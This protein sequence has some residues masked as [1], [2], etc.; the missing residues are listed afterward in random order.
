MGNGLVTS[1]QSLFKKAPKNLAIFLH[2]VLQLSRR[3]PSKVFC[4]AFFQKSDRL[5]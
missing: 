5:I 2:G 3:T 4:G 1:K